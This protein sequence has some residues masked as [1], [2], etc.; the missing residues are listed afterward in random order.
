MSAL[1][2]LIERQANGENLTSLEFAV[3]WCTDRVCAEKA[4]EILAVM[5]TQIHN[6]VCFLREVENDVHCDNDGRGCGASRKAGDL[7][8]EITTALQTQNEAQ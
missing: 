5:D 7:A 6:A 4:A 1:Q 2:K 8:D 3:F